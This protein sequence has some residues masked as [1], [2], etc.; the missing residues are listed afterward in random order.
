MKNIFLYIILVLQSSIASAQFIINGTTV[1][2]TS[3]S[4]LVIAGMDLENKTASSTNGDISLGGTIYIDGDWTN[5]ATGGELLD[6]S[7]TAGTV[8][9]NGSSAQTISGQVTNFYNITINSGAIVEVNAGDL[10]KVHNIFTNN[11]NFRLKASSNY[12]ACLIDAGVSNKLLGSGNFILQRVIPNNG[13]HYTSSPL[14][15]SSSSTNAYW[16]AALYSYTQTAPYWQAHVANEN[17][18]VMKAYDALYKNVSPTIEYSG[19]FN[20]GNQ[21]INLTSNGNEKYNFVGNPYPCTID[22][23]ASS[24]WTKTNVDDAIYI[25]DATLN[26]GQGGYMEYVG[27]V[28]QAGGSRYIPPSMGFFVRVCSTETSGVLGVSNSVKVT[29]TSTQYRSSD[30][31][32]ILRVKIVEGNYSN[33]TVIR[34]H[35]EATENFDGKYDAEKFFHS[36][37]TIPQ[38]Y[39]KINDEI[40]SINSVGFPEDKE[41]IP[42]NY[43]VGCEGKHRLEFDLSNFQDAM[44]NYEVL[45]EDKKTGKIVDLKGQ[46]VYEFEAEVT[47]KDDRFLIHINKYQSVD[48]PNNN[49]TNIEKT[50]VKKDYQIFVEQQSIVIKSENMTGELSIYDVSGRMVYSQDL[51]N[52][53]FIQYQPMTKGVYMV[54]FVSDGNLVYEKV[55]VD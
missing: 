32:D 40:Y 45:L 2:T 43:R 7:A 10:V 3:G 51:R 50:D 6:A 17:M 14:T 47:D 44:T 28:G 36:N 20:T 54:S 52:Q 1:S 11:G 46:D 23:D 49:F 35:Q 41:D 8:V 38:V 5:N 39:T 55:F 15:Y 18:V 22:W 33:S 13:W 19:V 21:S 37:P 48:N 29:E 34:L 4:A 53:S 16:G 9:F 12:I 27:G 25:W 42:L 31:N 26:S 24:G 30:A